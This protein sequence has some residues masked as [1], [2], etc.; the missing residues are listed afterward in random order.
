MRSQI[1]LDDLDKSTRTLK[2]ETSLL[3]MLPAKYFHV[4]CQK[5]FDPTFTEIKH[6]FRPYTYATVLDEG[7]VSYRELV[8][9]ITPAAHDSYTFGDFGFF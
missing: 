5:P 9:C 7:H 4:L 2:Q 6:D 8:T 3:S 1:K